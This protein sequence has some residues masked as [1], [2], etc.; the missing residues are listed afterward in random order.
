[1][2]GE[3][4]EM[5]FLSCPATVDSGATSKAFGVYPVAAGATA[6]AVSGTYPVTGEPGPVPPTGPGTVVDCP[7]AVFIKPPVGGEGGMM[8]LGGT[9]N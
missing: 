9:G 6:V 7:G 8:L 5:M 2:R 1:M 4:E 3:P